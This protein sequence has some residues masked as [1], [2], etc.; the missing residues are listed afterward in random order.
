M[1]KPGLSC[2]Y[3]CEVQSILS[4]EKIAFGYPV[5]QND[6]LQDDCSFQDQIHFNQITFP[7]LEVDEIVLEKIE[8]FSMEEMLHSVFEDIEL[9]HSQ[10]D[11]LDIGDK[12]LLGSKQYDVSGCLSDHYL[13]FRSS[14]S[15]LEFLDNLPEVDLESL[16]EIS[17]NKINSG[18]QW[19][20]DYDC[21]LSDKTVVYEEFQILDVDSLPI[22]ETLLN[23][24]VTCE[25]EPCVWMFNE[26]ANFKD[27]N[28]LIVSHELTLVD[29]SFK[30]LPVP[31]ICDDEKIS[32]IYAIIEGKLANLR[33]Q[34]PSALDGI[35]LDWHLL[36]DNKYSNT[37]YCENI[38]KDVGSQSID[39]DWDSFGDRSAV[40]DF[41]L[42]D[43]RPYGFIMDDNGEPKE[44]RSDL[45]IT[46][47]IGVAGESSSKFPQ[48]DNGE[49]MAKKNSGTASLL[50][51][52]NSESTDLDI[53]LNAQKATKQRTGE[54][55]IRAVSNNATSPKSSLG[56]SVAAISRG[57]E[58]VTISD[59]DEN[60]NNQKQCFNYLSMEKEYDTGAKEAPDKVEATSVPFPFMPFMKESYDSMVS[61]PETVIVVNTQTLDKMIVSRSTYQR[62]L[63]LEKEGA[64]VVERDSDLPVDIIVNSATCLVW[65]D[66]RNIGKKATDSDEASSC[67]PLCIDNIATNVLTL[68]SFN[69][70][71]CIMVRKR[72]YSLTL[73]QYKRIRFIE[74]LLI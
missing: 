56:N 20:S 47:S 21:S 64:Q 7:V 60:V 31:V 44:F 40:Y 24:Q 10:K 1:L 35:Y 9:E 5:G 29:D 34:P 16:V 71:G 11:I 62:I 30:S 59:M 50:F 8:D 17:Q 70:S 18:A 4:V 49:R 46:T 26:E 13:S 32:S 19:T 72:Y 63:A 68:L 37:S 74:I 66:S 15:E 38:L 61:F 6:N 65:Y 52:P 45:S 25:P 42:S 36:E 41:V 51:R 48:A 53:F 28:Q 12:E 54:P 73:F 57:R 33:P 43:D 22:F 27:F 14:G 39:Y 2:H 55:T 58:S 3:P 67:L 23:Q 69:F